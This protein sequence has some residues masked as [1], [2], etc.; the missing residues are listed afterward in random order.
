MQAVDDVNLGEGL[1]GALPQLVPRL[2]ERHRVRPVVAG[3]QAGEGAEQ[4]AGDTD[5]GR[6]EPDV[7]VV[8]GPRGVPLFAFAIGQPAERQ[9]V[10]TVEERQAI[11]EGK[12][13][14]GLEFVVD[15]G[16]AERC[17]ATPH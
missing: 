15:A 12:A 5:V 4:A 13:D 8:V 6:F 1:M 3:L 14:T 2:F 11:V 7:E 10:R 16:E 9:R 17:E